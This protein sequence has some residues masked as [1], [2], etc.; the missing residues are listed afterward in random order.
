[1]VFDPDETWC[2]EP[3]RLAS[4]AANTPLIGMELQGRAKMTF[5]GGDE[6]HYAQ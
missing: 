3:A 2:P 4:R 6:R 1:V 5:V